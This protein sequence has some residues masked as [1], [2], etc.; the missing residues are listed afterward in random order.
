MLLQISTQKHFNLLVSLENN[1]TSQINN[2]LNNTLVI[3]QGSFYMI[4]SQ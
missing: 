2:I 4:V 1:T 3:Q